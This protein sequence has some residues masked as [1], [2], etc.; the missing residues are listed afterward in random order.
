L[1]TRLKAFLLVLLFVIATG[2][3]LVGRRFVFAQSYATGKN[4]CVPGTQ[5]AFGKYGFLC[6]P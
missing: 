1:S 2:L 4:G 3:V 5:F 6:Y